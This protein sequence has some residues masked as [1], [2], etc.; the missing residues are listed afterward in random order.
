[1][2][3]DSFVKLIE[4][5]R[6]LMISPSGIFFKITNVLVKMGLLEGGKGGGAPNLFSLSLE[7]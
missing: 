2:Y 3:T 7:T 5:F 1:M 6:T 4:N